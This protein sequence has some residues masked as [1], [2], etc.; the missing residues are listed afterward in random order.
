MVFFFFKRERT[1]FRMSCQVKQKAGCG[2]VLTM[3][4]FALERKGYE[5]A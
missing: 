2:T 4:P 3:L 1:F 5:F